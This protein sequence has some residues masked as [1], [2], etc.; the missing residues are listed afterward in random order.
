MGDM[1]GKVD[2]SKGAENI[3]AF[4]TR[5]EMTNLQ[6]ETKA[7]LLK[8]RGEVDELTQHV[9]HLVKT[10]REFKDHFNSAMEQINDTF[11][12]ASQ[13]KGTDAKQE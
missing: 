4:A 2:F 7:E 11:L 13:L 8:M 1:I 5:K 9:L 12:Q 10:L 6:L 3:L